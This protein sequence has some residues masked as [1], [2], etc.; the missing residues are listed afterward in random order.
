M[1]YAGQPV[2]CALAVGEGYRCQGYCQLWMWRLWEAFF[3]EDAFEGVAEVWVFYQV[4][5]GCVDCYVGRS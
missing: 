5:G 1:P 2:A 4:R 3:A